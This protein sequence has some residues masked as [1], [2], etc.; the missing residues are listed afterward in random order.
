M[1]IITTVLRSLFLV[2]LLSISFSSFSQT[3]EEGE[4]L[5]NAN[6]TSCH[7]INEKVVG[8]ALK[9]MHTKHKEDWLIK[10][11][12]N[13]QALIKSGDAAAVQLYKDNN[14]SVMTSFENLS[15]VQIKSIIAYVKAESEKPAATATASAGPSVS[16]DGGTMSNG[17][18]P[19]KSKINWLLFI[20]AALLIGVIGQVMGILNKVGE[21]QGKPVFN[22]SSI[23]AKLLL[24]FLVTGMAAAAWEFVVHGKLTV[25]AQDAA[26]EHGGIYDSMFN[27]TL[28]ITGIV[29]VITQ[30]LL[31]WYGYRYRND[32][33]RKAVYYPD[34]HK[35]ELIWTVIPAI[36][37]TILVIRGLKTWNN[38]M[39]HQDEKAA[40]VE[41]YGY[42][43]GWNARYAG[44]DNKLGNHD[45]RQIGVVNALGVDPKDPKAQDDII[46]NELHFPVGKPVSL[47]FRA[48]DVIHSAYLPHFR[49]QMNV[50]PGLPTQFNFTPT[51]TTSE[52]RNKL[53]DPK[54]DYILL[55]NKICGGAHYRM[56][57]KV[58]VDSPE[59][60]AKWLAAQ[61]TLAATSTPAPAADSTAAQA[62]VNLTKQAKTLAS[63]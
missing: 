4:K 17:E 13:S 23:N 25:N 46:V 45:F 51:I 2:S 38:I 41:V 19:Y 59:E 3:V 8:P 34:N 31:F 24:A 15:D 12:R 44:I 26:S 40:I 47:K 20:V 32:G 14:E 11:I 35:L 55:C 49:V 39:N 6:C 22:W 33:K 58:I 42:Q 10:W 53:N 56:K 50:V 37:L 43:F 21:I 54:F 30:I 28:I 60:Y 29:F 27:I 9:G 18:N 57:M 5:F 52:M 61:P 63:K 36:V 16:A 7:A 62:S 1:R 48:K